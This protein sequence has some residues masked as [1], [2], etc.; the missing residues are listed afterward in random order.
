MERYSVG[1]DAGVERQIYG[2]YDDNMKLTHQISCN[3]NPAARPEDSMDLMVKQ[4]QRLVQE[5][6]ASMK[7]LKGVGVAFPAH[8]DFAQGSI[9]AA[10][11]MRQFNGYSLCDEL[12]KRMDLPVWLDNDANAAA[13]A[14]FKLGAGKGC[15]HMLYLQL[16]T[17]IGGGIVINRQ[18]FRGNYGAA[19]EFGHM[20]VSDSQGF[21]CGC[22][23]TGCVQSLAA[24]PMLVRYAQEKIEEGRQSILPELAGSVDQISLKNIALAYRKKDSLA[25]EIMDLA[26]ETLGRMF[27]SLYQAFNIANVVYGG[28]LVKLGN[29][30]VDGMIIRFLQNCEMARKYPVSF[31]PAKLGDQGIMLGAALLVGMKK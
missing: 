16:G 27:V 5:A 20:L 9:I 28:D 26:V 17:G 21:L 4:I 1:I 25:M 19:G 13:Y 29:A 3:N 24:V 2:L 11:N 15:D 23:M 12:E 6:G 30:L 8:I 22:G 10:A 31:K 7:Q 18:I 14:E